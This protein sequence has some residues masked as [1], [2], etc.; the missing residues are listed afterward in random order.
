MTEYSDDMDSVAKNIWAAK[1][2]TEEANR[3]L[4]HPNAKASDI[5]DETILRVIHYINWN[6]RAMNTS[7]FSRGVLSM[8]PPKVV[9]AKC[10]SLIKR[11]LITGCACGCRGD[12][13]IAYKTPA[14]T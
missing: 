2:F 14:N 5:A 13:W 1:R 12:F 4:P 8:Y 3:G 10:R 6:G 11:G 9:Q 7:D